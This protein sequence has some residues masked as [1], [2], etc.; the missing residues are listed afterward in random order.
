MPPGTISRQPR[1]PRVGPG[2]D[3]WHISP[4]GAEHPFTARQAI[5]FWRDCERFVT[6]VAPAVAV[7]ARELLRRE[8]LTGDEV[9]QLASTAMIGQ[10]PVRM[11]LWTAEE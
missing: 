3:L 6:S 2:E 9:A 1:G 5:D 7:I 8:F 10:S 4:E 11:P